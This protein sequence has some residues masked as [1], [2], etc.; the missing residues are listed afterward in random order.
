MAES[1]FGAPHW[2]KSRRSG[3]GGDCVEVAALGEFVAVR[4]SKDP[5]GPVLTFPV[6]TWRAFVAAIRRGE[7]DG[8]A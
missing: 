4:D 8:T 7:F 6:P 5:T 3:N 2:R 1:T